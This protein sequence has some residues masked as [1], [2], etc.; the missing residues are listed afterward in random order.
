MTWTII[1]HSV[2]Q[3]L[4]FRYEEGA[5]IPDGTIP[6]PLDPRVYRP[7]DRPGGAVPAYVAGSGTQAVDA[8]LVRQGFRAGWTGPLG[9]EWVEAGRK[10]AAK[11]GVPLGL[12][13]MPRMDESAGVPDG[14]CAARC[15]CGRMGMW[16]G[17]SRICR[18]IRR[19]AVATSLD[20]LLHPARV[21]MQG[22]ADLPGGVR[23]AYEV[24]GSGAPLVLIHGAEADHTM[25]DAFVPFLSGYFAC[26]GYDQRD[27]GGTVNPEAPYNVLDMADDAA[28]LI[29]AL[30]HAKAHVFG[31]LVGQ[32]HRPGAGGAA[33]GG[34][35]SAG[36]VVGDQDRAQR[37]GYRTGD[38]GGTGP[39][40]GRPSAQCHGDC[41]VFL[42]GGSTGRA[43]GA[44]RSFQGQQAH[45][46]AASA[47]ECADPRRRRYCR[48]AGS[49]RRRCW[50]CTPRTS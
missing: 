15:W 28:A 2:G 46:R 3:A 32:C 9:G 39:A 4:D 45:A 18:T 10:A 49:A 8:G 5:V 26:I 1:L 47:A 37:R 11:V 29:S 40:A 17:G 14:G 44:G 22:V 42:H 34:G 23:V 16:R 7:S 41:S 33:S 27:S 31:T 12:R 13:T 48:L 38:G 24:T 25:F 21:V 50:W 20:T 36:I 19:A 35:G 6:R 43:S 30:G